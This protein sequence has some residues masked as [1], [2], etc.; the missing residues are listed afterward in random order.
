MAEKKNYGF[1][2]FYN[3]FEAQ[4]NFAAWQGGVISDETH[5]KVAKSEQAALDV[6]KPEAQQSGFFAQRQ[7]LSGQFA[8]HFGS[9]YGIQHWDL[10]RRQ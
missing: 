1:F 2:K 7:W 9:M 5:E 6:G 8:K 3:G 10:A 4:G